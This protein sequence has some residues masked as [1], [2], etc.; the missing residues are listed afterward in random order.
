MY[1][2]MYTPWFT[3]GGVPFETVWQENIG[4][5]INLI[6][7]EHESYE[8]YSIEINSRM[9]RF[10]SAWE[11]KEKI[12]CKTTIKYLLLKYKTICCG[13]QICRPWQMRQNPLMALL[14]SFFLDLSCRCNLRRH[15]P[16]TASFNSSLECLLSI[17]HAKSSTNIREQYK[18]V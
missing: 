1:S 11:R 16:A 9:V 12:F 15:W 5:C 8:K 4:T 13:R 7:A 14:P 6:F 18:H 3:S 10:L 2:Y 17:T